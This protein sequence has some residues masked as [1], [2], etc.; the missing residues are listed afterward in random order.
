[1]D[2][3]FDAY[4]TVTNHRSRCC[5]VIGLAG[6]LDM[7]SAHHLEAVLD[8]MMV[9]P[10]HIIIDVSGLTF[11]DSHGLRLLARASELVEGSLWL[12]GCS[13]H[14]RKLLDIT[15]LDS[16]FCME[17]DWNAAHEEFAQRR[18]S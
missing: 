10:D 5:E 1:M 8:R 16:F 12:K 3:Y 9:I 17:D 11:I 14:I 18:V 6:E 13:S 4:F 15:A 7:A 2:A